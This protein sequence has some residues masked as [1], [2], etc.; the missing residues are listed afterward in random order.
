MNGAIKIEEL[1]L[2]ALLQ[3]IVIIVAARL[4]AALFRKF[5]QPSVV[6]EIA[7]GLVLGPSCFGYFFPQVSRAVFDPSLAE[8][9][10]VLSQL[11]LILLLFV[12]TGLR[13]NIGTLN[14]AMH[15][16]LLLGVLA[17]AVAGKLGGCWVAARAGGFPPRDAA[18]IGT[19]MNT[20]GLMELIVINLGRDLGVIPDSVFCMLT[21]MALVTTLMTTPLLMHFMRHTELE[22]FIRQS[23]FGVR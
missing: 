13:T 21:I 16:A 11:G 17:C 15:W 19:L 6:G 7:A 18:C 23:K 14:T 12:D 1:L 2:N 20:R 10:A 9:F 22:P 5:R 4:F 8:T 3:L